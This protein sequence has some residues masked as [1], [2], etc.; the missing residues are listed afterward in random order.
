MA[1]KQNATT[2]APIVTD[3]TEITDAPANTDAPEV[4]DTPNTDAP[5]STD[6]PKA[7]EP[8]RINLHVLIDVDPSKW[9]VSEISDEAAAER[10]KLVAVLVAGGFSQADAEATANKVHKPV[11][12]DGPAAVR[13]AVKAYM[14]DSMRGLTRITEAGAVVSYYERPVKA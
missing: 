14:L 12:G 3:V 8:M 7:G 9:D 11:T 5:E 10:T 13:D 4:T 2:D 6:A 1:T